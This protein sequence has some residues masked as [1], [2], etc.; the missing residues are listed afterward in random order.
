MSVRLESLLDAVGDGVNEPIYLV[1]GNLV[2]AEPTARK[3]AEALAERGGAEVE[4]V[5]R[6][7]RLGDLLG[8]LRTYSLFA[9]CR[10]ML[11]VESALLADRGAAAALVDEV[12]E[13][14]PVSSEDAE[15]DRSER[16]AAGRLLQ[17]LRLFE[18]DPYNGPPAEVLA[19]LP[20]WTFEGGRAK[21]RRK[22]TKGKVETLR[23]ELAALLE[24][25]RLSGLQGSGEGESLALT[26]TQAHPPLAERCVEPVLEVPEKRGVGDGEGRAQ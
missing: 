17:I 10:V 12:A 26:T 11:V 8:D 13:A 5:R 19:R 25:A 24:K 7:S 1:S 6:P 20:A 22:R 14:L 23:T 16:A 9:G 15:L 18:I 3:L 2:L 4:V 21:G